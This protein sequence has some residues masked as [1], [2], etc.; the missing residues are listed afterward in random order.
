MQDISQK[1]LKNYM[2]TFRE[3]TIEDKATVQKYT[4]GSSRRNC[5]LTF[6]NLYSWRFLYDTEIAEAD[7]FLLIRFITEG[8]P[9]YML[10]VG[11]G[12]MRQIVSD[13]MAH[14]RE[15]GEHF[16]M[17]GV[18]ADTVPVIEGLF[19]DTFTFTPERDFADYIYLHSDL[20]T[21]K[22]KKYQ[23]KRNHVNK[24]RS[25][26]PNY[27]FEPL[28]PEHV[29]ECIRLE[30]QWCKAENHKEHME[31]QDERKSINA[32]LA[33]MNELDIIGGVL[34]VEGQVAG[35]TYGAP[36]NHETFDT[37]VEKA[38]TNYEGAYTVINQ[39]F[40]NMIPQQ[41][42]YIN[43]EEDL[44]IDGLRQAKLSY[45]PFLL[46]DKYRMELK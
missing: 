6:A 23:P 13:I 8:K 36:L 25:L 18:C 17:F 38:D 20:A 29:P 12:D 27:T 33:R 15:N 4:L 1:K 22:G 16:R 31:L 11:N 14:A 43:R 26:Y 41:Y 21:L 37:C 9:A 40:A 28:T 24:F 3:L 42:I 10:P 7:G 39:E 19:P 32:A 34:K 30:T 2:I 35:F 44:G 5:D 46:L 45:K